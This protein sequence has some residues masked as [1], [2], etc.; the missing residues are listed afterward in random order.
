[1]DVCHDK[2]S[3]LFA[4]R[5]W[6]LSVQ[7]SVLHIGMKIALASKRRRFPFA[8]GTNF[9]RNGDI[10]DQMVVIFIEEELGSHID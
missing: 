8:T 6:A 3:A 9:G 1:M 2:Y 5:V 4:N 7:A 10:I